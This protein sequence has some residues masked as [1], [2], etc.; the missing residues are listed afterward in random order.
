MKK[1]F[2]LFLPLSLFSQSYDVLFLGNSYTAYNNLPN[3]VSQIAN[4]LD[5]TLN[6]YSNTPGGWTLEQHAQAGSSSRQKI[7]EQQWDFV[8]IQAQSNEPSFPPFQV[9]EQTYPYAETLVNAIED[10]YLCS[11]PVFYMTWGRE[12]GDNINGPQYPII[13]TYAGMQQ[14]LRE[15]YLEMGIN[16][17]ATVSPVG[18]AW[19]QMREQYPNV[20]LYSGDE[21]HPSLAGSYLAAC[22]HYC[23]IFAKSC[24]SSDT[25]IPNGLDVTVASN[26]QTIASN[27]V[28]DSTQ[29]WNMFYIQSL[30]TNKINQTSYEFDLQVSNYD[31]IYW[32]FGDNTSVSNSLNVEHEYIEEGSYNVTLTVSS[33]GCKILSQTIVI[34]IPNGSTDTTGGNDTT[35]IFIYDKEDNLS[36]YPNPANQFIAF[37]GKLSKSKMKIINVFSEV[38][39]EKHIQKGEQI[40]ISNLSSG[41]YIIELGST[42][43]IK[44]FKLIKNE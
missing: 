34:S 3:L 7:T 38:V 17:N 16:N 6:P 39:L 32:D 8:V 14:R 36:L 35:S 20:N 25:Y 10:N 1:L 40:D 43:I 19:Y 26:I 2:L 41:Y 27:T 15:S 4:S 23:T 42:E 11:E 31:S 37:E 24:Q 5:D 22:V 28:L 18:M 29:V 21:S 12:N 13:S 9:Q 33:N 30:D 44:T